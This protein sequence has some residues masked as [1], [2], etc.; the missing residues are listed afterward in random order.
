MCKKIHWR[1]ELP[2]VVRQARYSIEEQQKQL[3]EQKRLAEQRRKLE[4]A[5]EKARRAVQAR[6]AAKQ[7]AVVKEEKPIRPRGF[8]GGRLTTKVEEILGG[9]VKGEFALQDDFVPFC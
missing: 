1:G 2:I 9:G 5:K 3:E 6:L 8:N 7:P 4:E